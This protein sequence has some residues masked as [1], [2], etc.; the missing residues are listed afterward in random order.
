MTNNFLDTILQAELDEACVNLAYFR[1]GIAY[2]LLSSTSEQALLVE[3]EGC[4]DG[5]IVI[6]AEQSHGRGR[7]ARSWITQRGD[8][9]L[10]L[11]MR[12]PLLPRA[13]T[14]LSLLPALALR[15]ALV[16]CGLVC[17]VKWPNDIVVPMQIEQI[18]DYFLH[19]RKLG[20]ILVE[21]ICND[22]GISA[23]II[24]IGLNIVSKFH[25][26]DTIPHITSVHEQGVA[27]SRAH[28]LKQ[29]LHALEQRLFTTA[30]SATILGEYRAHCITLGQHVSIDGQ[31]AQAID[32]NEHGALVVR[33]G[34]GEQIIHAGDVHMVRTT[35][36]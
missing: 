20:G 6:A 33:S 31:T 4:Y 26:R 24:G 28:V 18:T 2:R 1:R 25:H 9:A 29:L 10:S 5:T 30:S 19:Y 21:N 32:I 11:I 12:E 23:S 35:K 34:F 22:N 14:L 17:Y 3:K 8:I 13:A 16:S 15:D 36:L 7:H 27:I